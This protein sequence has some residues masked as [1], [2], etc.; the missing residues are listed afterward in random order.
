MQLALVFFLISFFVFFVGGE[1]G[2]LFC[3][4]SPL[5]KHFSDNLLLEPDGPVLQ[6]LW[7]RYWRTCPRDGGT[8]AAAARSG[9]A[10]S[11]HTSAPLG[12]TSGTTWSR[13]TWT[14]STTAP[15]VTRSSGRGMR[16]APTCIAFTRRR[17]WPVPSARLTLPPSAHFA[18]TRRLNISARFVFTRRLNISARL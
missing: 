12:P 2:M 18:F 3:E 13:S 7:T 6:L 8:R 14:G 9:V 17:R 11:A 16:C 1:C 5:S 15:P 4:L 10:A